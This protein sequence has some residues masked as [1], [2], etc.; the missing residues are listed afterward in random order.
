MLNCV[1]AIE[2]NNKMNLKKNYSKIN[3]GSKFIH[4]MS[5]NVINSC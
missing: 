5:P 1:K 4:E 2:L 3:N